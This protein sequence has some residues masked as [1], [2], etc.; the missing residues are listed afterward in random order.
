MAV[1]AIVSTAVLATIYTA[2]ETVVPSL[3]QA[4][5]GIAGLSALAWVLVNELVGLARMD[6]PA[7]ARP[8]RFLAPQTG[9][10]EATAFG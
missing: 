5:L 3:T 7:S 10:P 8:E 2:N 9:T 6:S 4:V 1:A